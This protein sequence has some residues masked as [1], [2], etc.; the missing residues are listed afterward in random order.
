MQEAAANAQ[1][2]MQQQYELGMRHYG[3]VHQVMG[4]LAEKHDLTLKDFASVGGD[5]MNADP[6]F[7]PKM[8]ATEITHI[9]SLNPTSD[10]EKFREIANQYRNEALTAQQQ[11]DAHFRPTAINTGG[12]TQFVNT[13][14]GPIQNTASPE[15]LNQPVT[16]FDP[17][18]GA[19]VSQ[20]MSSYLQATK[21]GPVQAGPAQGTDTAAYA[22]AN[23]NA[24]RY[25]QS[26]VEAN[27]AHASK[28][29][30]GN[31]SGDLKQF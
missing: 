19:P 25:Q 30:L 13:A 8:V 7:T 12:T 28:S 31:M 29:L 21:G 9:A 24:Q 11:I 4:A 10:P 17:K 14:P 22:N 6:S 26:L 23:A 2:Q 1:T 15:S 16:T 20:P 18:T 27:E 5:L 3:M